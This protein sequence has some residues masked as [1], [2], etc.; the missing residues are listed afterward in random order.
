MRSTDA[1]PEI[2]FAE[3][4]DQAIRYKDNPGAF[5]KYLGSKIDRIDDYQQLGKY[6]RKLGKKLAREANYDRLIGLGNSTSIE[7]K[8]T[9]ACFDIFTCVRSL[10]EHSTYINDKLTPNS[11]FMLDMANYICEI[12]VA[13]SE[14]KELLSNKL[15]VM[16]NAPEAFVKSLD[17]IKVSKESSTKQ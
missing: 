14:N 10:I 11:G 6:A 16:L 2:N 7:N 17:P 15:Q 3:I 5:E 12:A 4:R 9:K 13:F 8:D 1:K